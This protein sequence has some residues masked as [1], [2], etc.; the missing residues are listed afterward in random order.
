MSTFGNPPSSRPSPVNHN[1]AQHPNGPTS[2]PPL[3]TD[4]NQYSPTLRGPSSPASPSTPVYPKSGR[5]SRP[6][7]MVFQQSPAEIGR[8]TVP[9]LLP[10]FTFLN[11]HANKL[12]QEGY[13][14]KLNDLDNSKWTARIWQFILLQRQA[15]ALLK[16][17]IGQN[18]LHSSLGLFCHF[19]M[20]QH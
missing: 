12:Y 19:G 13:F 14:L 16:I 18:V 1:S 10:I 3:K 15:D 11:S 7:S 5:S 8:D 9:E 17:E 4:L 2:V 20:P 6:G